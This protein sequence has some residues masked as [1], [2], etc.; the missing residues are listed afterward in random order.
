MIIKMLLVRLFIN[1]LKVNKF[2]KNN[3]VCHIL[4]HKDII[5]RHSNSIHLSLDCNKFNNLKMCT[6]INKK[7]LFLKL[8]R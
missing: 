4:K 6:K 8:I 3:N 5:N 2:N 1:I 7:I